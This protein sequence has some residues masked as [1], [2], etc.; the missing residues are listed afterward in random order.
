MLSSPTH[1][2][3][4]HVTQFSTV[5]L[6]TTTLALMLL[7]ITGVWRLLW[8]SLM[9]FRELRDTVDHYLARPQRSSDGGKQLQRLDSHPYV[10]LLAFL[11]LPVL[12]AWL[13]VST[14]VCSAAGFAA[15][16]D[17]DD[18]EAD[19][20]SG[21]WAQLL[22]YLCTS[23]DLYS[24]AAVAAAVVCWA[25]WLQLLML[26]VPN[27]TGVLQVGWL[28]PTLGLG[29]ALLTGVTA[30]LLL[31][32]FACNVYTVF[33][34]TLS[35]TYD[36]A[37]SIVQFSRSDVGLPVVG[38]GDVGVLPASQ[39]ALCPP[40]SL[41]Y[42]FYN[43]G[44]RHV[45]ASLSGAGAPLR[46]SPAQCAVE[47]LVNAACVSPTPTPQR[48]VAVTSSEVALTLKLLWLLLA[49]TAVVAVMLRARHH[50]SLLQPPSLD[51]ATR[52]RQLR[53]SVVDITPMV[54][55]LRVTQLCGL[56]VAGWVGF[57]IHGVSYGYAL[58]SCVAV[59]LPA[60]YT[61]GMLT[62][63]AVL[64]VTGT[65]SGTRARDAPSLRAT[66]AYV[67]GATV[68]AAVVAV[69]AHPEFVAPGSCGAT[70]L[71]TLL[72]ATSMRQ[73][74]RRW[75]SPSDRSGTG[76]GDGV[77]D[78][79]E[80]V[81][82]RGGGTGSGDVPAGFRRNSSSEVTRGVG[83]PVAPPAYRRGA[84]L[85]R[86]GSDKGVQRA[87]TAVDGGAV[88]AALPAV[89]APQPPAAVSVP[90]RDGAGDDPAAGVSM[91]KTP[92]RDADGSAGTHPS[93]YAA[94]STIANG[95]A[96]VKRRAGEPTPLT[97]VVVTSPTLLCRND[98]AAVP[99]WC[100]AAVCS[101]RVAHLVHQCV[102]RRHCRR[103][104][105]HVRRRQQPAAGGPL[106]ATADDSV[107]RQR[108][109][110]IRGP[111]DGCEAAA[112]LPVIEAAPAGVGRATQRR[113][114]PSSA[115]LAVHIKY[116]NRCSV[117]W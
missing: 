116:D 39:S 16:V 20:P 23:N 52:G 33:G 40:R 66:V 101:C 27:F 17:G 21:V 5:V 59:I 82:Y 85:R 64:L 9:G 84:A 53:R 1:G 15:A 50:A 13:T 62:R 25:Q 105:L 38:S 54:T 69:T 70:F 91:M 112:A 100:Y 36:A 115:L 88:T 67:V 79:D 47:S 31:G 78:S 14:A 95:L 42:A 73:R 86:R 3:W 83:I 103:R 4:T 92:P 43:N 104:R 18:W 72:A 114:G 109:V 44:R 32:G 29:I 74:Y 89:A 99:L 76:D 7:L 41:L 46:D 87:G 75:R 77:D 113:Q 90:A 10:M 98:C 106:H 12:T 35:S 51:T 63:R 102:G 110:P 60:L 37:A 107:L 93:P 19:P 94:V 96:F 8:D 61:F 45:S 48:D 49:T 28:G 111:C 34:W 6:V 117:V 30:P 58:L 65:D 108:R 22:H 11:S 80:P 57:M 2:A 97:R 68:F 71:I 56:L 55:M 24:K 81:A 26:L